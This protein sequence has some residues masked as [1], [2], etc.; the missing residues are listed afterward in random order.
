MVIK[1][2]L[3]V[4]PSEYAGEFISN[5]GNLGVDIALSKLHL[6][7]RNLSQRRL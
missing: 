3:L 5:Y 6:A 2:W 4:G 1:H 7:T